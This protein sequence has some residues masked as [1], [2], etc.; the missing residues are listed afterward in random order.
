MEKFLQ[1]AVLQEPRGPV[2]YNDCAVIACGT[3]ARILT[4]EQHGLASTDMPSQYQIL[5]LPIC[6]SD[7]VLETQDA[8]ATHVACQE[9]TC[10]AQLLSVLRRERCAVFLQVGV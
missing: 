9:C 1:V 8:A 4:E 5:G 2:F 10:D 6:G 7:H 3:H